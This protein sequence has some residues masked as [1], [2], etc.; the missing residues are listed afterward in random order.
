MVHLTQLK[1][2]KRGQDSSFFH[3]KGIQ[4]WRNPV[5]IMAALT[6]RDSGASNKPINSFPDLKIDLNVS[7]S[8]TVYEGSFESTSIIRQQLMPLCQA[9]CWL[10]LAAMILSRSIKTDVIQASNLLILVSIPHSSLTVLNFINCLRSYVTLAK[11][12]NK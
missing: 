4:I 5:S 9:F 11:R 8:L 3:I 2:K 7:L 12:I 10:T 6:H 1:K